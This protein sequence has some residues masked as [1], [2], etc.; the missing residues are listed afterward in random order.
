MRG[1]PDFGCLT[2]A[3][4]PLYLMGA[5]SRM[6]ANSRVCQRASVQHHDTR[7]PCTIRHTLLG[8]EECSGHVVFCRAYAVVPLGMTR[9]SEAGLFPSLPRGEWRLS[10]SGV[11][12]FGGSHRS[13]RQTDFLCQPQHFLATLGWYTT[14]VVRHKICVGGCGHVQVRS[15]FWFF[16]LGI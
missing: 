1:L 10:L 14:A 13:P 9:A 15:I 11:R 6:G 7:Q 3:V 12:I 16:V 4:L 8:V 2:S 5:P